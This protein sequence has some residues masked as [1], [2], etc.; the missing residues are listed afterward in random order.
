MVW[1]V[2]VAGQTCILIGQN[3]RLGDSVKCI[4]RT[5]LHCYWSY[6]IPVVNSHVTLTELRSDW[7]TQIAFPGPRIVSIFTRPLFP[8]RGW[9]LGTRLT[10]QN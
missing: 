8:C 10:R 3:T 9:G 7:D 2:I 1:S 4:A 5:D 6:Q